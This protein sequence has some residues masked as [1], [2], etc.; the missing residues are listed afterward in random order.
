MKKTYVK[1]QVYF[2]DFQLNASIAA[3]CPRPYSGHD[4]GV[5]GIKL[6]PDTYYMGDITGCVEK[7]ANDGEMSICYHNPDQSQN[8]FN[9]I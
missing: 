7:V 1:P 6:G 4:N 5:C 3:V 2:E 9:S 8:L